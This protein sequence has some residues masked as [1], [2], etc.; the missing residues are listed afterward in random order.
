MAAPG[1][2]SARSSLELQ[3]K[4]SCQDGILKGCQKMLVHSAVA[5]PLVARASDVGQT[6]VCGKLV[7]FF[8]RLVLL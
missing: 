7:A 6:G 1:T 2:S 8:S 5:R 3:L 4:S